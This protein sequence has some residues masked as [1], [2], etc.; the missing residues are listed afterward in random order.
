MMKKL[1]LADDS[2]TIQKVVGIILS[3]EEYQLE[4]TDDGD[5]ACLLYT[6]PSPRDS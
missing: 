2:I 6:S 5:R 3:T 4:M 1:L